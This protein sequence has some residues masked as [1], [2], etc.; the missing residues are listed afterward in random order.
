[1]HESIIEET[2]DA[3]D[4]RI[5]VLRPAECLLLERSQPIIAA[6]MTAIK[7]LNTIEYTLMSDDHAPKICASG[8]LWKFIE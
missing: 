5:N 7:I 6:R 4:I 8:S 3:I 2:H 1:M